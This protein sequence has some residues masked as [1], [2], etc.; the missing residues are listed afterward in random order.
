MRF[1]RSIILALGFVLVFVG[2]VKAKKAVSDQRPD[3]IDIPPI[4]KIMSDRDHGL[5]IKKFEKQFPS[6]ISGPLKN[7]APIVDEFSDAQLGRKFDAI[8]F[9]IFD[10]LDD[11]CAHYEYSVADLDT[12]HKRATG[13]KFTEELNNRLD[14]IFGRIRLKYPYE[15]LVYANAEVLAENSQDITYLSK[16]SASSTL[17]ESS[18]KD[19]LPSNAIDGLSSSCWCEGAVGKGEGEWI[20]LTFPYDIT[21]TSI[22]IIPGYD[23]YGGDA[24]GDRF[25]LNLR[26]KKARLEF[27]DGS[28][29]TV[30]TTDT[31]RMQNINLTPVKT[32]Y[33]KLIVEEVYSS[34]AKYDDLCISEFR[35]QGVP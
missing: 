11:V 6:R 9:D 21:V 35:V 13:R 27:S 33:V 18:Y 17:P 29:Q 5:V 32:S 12:T 24:V 26:L 19:Y 3:S 30:E 15:D 8:R 31:R 1:K 14:E 4:I 23:W 2:T 16:A 7:L 34:S 28:S 25:Y 22:G 10:M 20:K